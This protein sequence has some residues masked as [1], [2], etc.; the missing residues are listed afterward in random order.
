MQPPTPQQ[1]QL[2]F[3][4]LTKLNLDCHSWGLNGYCIITF[5]MSVLGTLRFVYRDPLYFQPQK[6]HVGMEFQNCK[7][8]RPWRLF[9]AHLPDTPSYCLCAPLFLSCHTLSLC[10]W[11]PT[12]VSHLNLIMMSVI[13]Q[14]FPCPSFVLYSISSSSCVVFKPHVI[15]KLWLIVRLA[16]LN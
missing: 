8:P 7:G 1:N 6:R 5:L 3:K 11:F 2:F 13:Y 9:L 15:V 16:R 4:A 12:H 14:F 10:A